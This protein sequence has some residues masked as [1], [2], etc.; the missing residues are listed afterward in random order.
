[1]SWIRKCFRL[2]PTSNHIDPNGVH[3]PPAEGLSA[4]NRS[5]FDTDPDGH[6]YCYYYEHIPEVAGATKLTNEF[7]LQLLQLTP[8]PML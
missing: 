1:M 2:Q 6:Q 3:R 5:I 4:L 7:D 8:S